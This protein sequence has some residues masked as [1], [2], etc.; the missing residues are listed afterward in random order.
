MAA[1]VYRILRP[2]GCF[3]V[4]VPDGELILRRYFDA[5]SELIARRG[6]DG[7][8]VMQVVNAYFR[9]RYEH[10]FLYDWPTME[11]MLRSA[12]FGQVVRASFGRSSF[13]EPLLLDDE[14]YAWESLYV[15]ARKC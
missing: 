13:S 14:K 1:E 6:T 15:E 4:I 10:Q 2:G 3:R 8:T 9:Q 12:G 11:R 5:P 7:N